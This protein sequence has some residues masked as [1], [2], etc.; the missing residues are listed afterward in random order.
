MKNYNLKIGQ[1]KP[2]ILQSVQANNYQYHCINL[3]KMMM[4]NKMAKDKKYCGQEVYDK[5]YPLR[6]DVIPG[7][8]DQDQNSL[9]IIYLSTKNKRPNEANF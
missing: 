3:R 9:I 4:Y 8:Q 1:D 2:N 7:N 6:F 5:V